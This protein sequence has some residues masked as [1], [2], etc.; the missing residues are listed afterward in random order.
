MFTFALQN[1]FEELKVSITC[2][3]RDLHNDELKKEV[4]YRLGTYLHWM[5]NLWERIEKNEVIQIAQEHKSLI[6]AFR[7][8]NNEL[9]HGKSLVT[10]YQR[11]G[12]FSFPISFPLVIEAIAFKWAKLEMS[13]KGHESQFTNYQLYLE[14]KQIIDTIIDAKEIVEKYNMIS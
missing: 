4:N 14:G 8:A 5:M 7:Y 6:S 9:K 13:N 12:G 10:L 2:A 1:S 3:E 11:T